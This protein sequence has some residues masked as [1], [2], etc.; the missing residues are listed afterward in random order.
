MRTLIIIPML[1]LSSLLFGQKSVM[2]RMVMPCQ[3]GSSTIQNGKAVIALDDYTAQMISNKDIH[4]SY[5]VTITPSCNCGEFYVSEKGDKSFTVQQTGNT[6]GPI[7]FDYI[8][9][10][11][12][13][14]PQTGITK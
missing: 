10:L 6:T 4:A 2:E 14:A 9:Y 7:T 12:R 11:K 13:G 1:F 8:V 3:A 5:Y